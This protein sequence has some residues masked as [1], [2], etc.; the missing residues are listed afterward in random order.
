[1]LGN[2]LV[3]DDDIDAAMLVRGELRKRGFNAHAVFSGEECLDHMRVIV[4]DVV[5]AEVHMATSPA[6]SCGSALR[7]RPP[8]PARS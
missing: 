2:V 4:S 3:V 8:I 6:S 7:A 5:I 1:M